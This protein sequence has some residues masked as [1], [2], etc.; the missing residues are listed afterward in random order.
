MLQRARGAKKRLFLSRV[1]CV[2][3]VLL[4]KILLRWFVVL[5]W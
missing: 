2:A 4:N 5:R 3:L 1:P